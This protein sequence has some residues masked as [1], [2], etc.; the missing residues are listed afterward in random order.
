MMTLACQ[1]DPN[2]FGQPAA[3]SQLPQEVRQRMISN[4]ALG[5]DGHSFMCGIIR[6]G[7]ILSTRA[8]AVPPNMESVNQ[9]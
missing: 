4:R 7:Q 1:V 2:R 8:S 6:N 3:Q 5:R 9:P